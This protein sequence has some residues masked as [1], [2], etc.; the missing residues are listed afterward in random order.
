MNSESSRVNQDRTEKENALNA[1]Q[2]LLAIDGDRRAFELLLKRWHPRLFKLALYLTGH[3]EDAEDVLQ[4]GLLAIAKNI[5]RLKEPEQFGAWACTIIRRRAA[6]KIKS[7]VRQRDIAADLKVQP[8]TEP[9]DLATNLTLRQLLENLPEQERGLMRL[10]YVQGFT[11]IEISAGLGIPVGT[12][13]SRLFHI[14]QKLKI[15]A[16]QKGD[17]NG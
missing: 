14:R 1:Y 6:D 4:D 5:G 9:S 17:Q 11:A 3:R 10:F 7:I 12:V 13:K 15:N 16:N 8:D 2:V